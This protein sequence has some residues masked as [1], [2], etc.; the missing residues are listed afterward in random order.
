MIQDL[1]LEMPKNAK[2]FK[3]TKNGNVYAVHYNHLVLVV[4]GNE[5]KDLYPAGQTSCDVIRRTIYHLGLSN[6]FFDI[7]PIYNKIHN[8]GVDIKLTIKLN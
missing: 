8:T 1:K 6:G 3:D 7:L 5:I 2:E 4:I